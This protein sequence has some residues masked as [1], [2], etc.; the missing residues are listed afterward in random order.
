[1]IRWGRVADALLREDDGVDA[2]GGR[3]Q[4]LADSQGGS[5]SGQRIEGTA[6]GDGG[7]GSDGGEGV[8]DAERKYIMVGV[9]GVCQGLGPGGGGRAGGKGGGQRSRMNVRTK[10]R[11]M[12]TAGLPCPRHPLRAPRRWSFRSTARSA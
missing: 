2:D 11:G 8:T 1:M 10:R 5:G 12:P 6:G 7:S 9:R 4:E 3:R